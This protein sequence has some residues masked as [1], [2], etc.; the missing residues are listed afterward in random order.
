MK[1]DQL[2]LLMCQ[3]PLK[4]AQCFHHSWKA[5]RRP[6]QGQPG[7]ELKV[8]YARIPHNDTPAFMKKHAQ[9]E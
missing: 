1:E 8:F 3:L 7:V 6:K 5:R 9:L 2:P 4:G